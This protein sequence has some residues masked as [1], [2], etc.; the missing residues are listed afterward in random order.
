MPHQAVEFIMAYAAELFDPDLVQLFARQIPIYPTG[1]TVKLNT[2][3]VGIVSDANLGH[4]GRPVV[5]V[6]FDDEQREVAEPYDLDL[7]D[8]DHQDRLVSQVMDY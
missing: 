1:V 8:P 4:I 3:E 5:R 2:G 6:C 7:S